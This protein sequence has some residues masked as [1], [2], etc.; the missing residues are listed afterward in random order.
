MDKSSRVFFLRPRGGTK[1]GHLSA[2][3]GLLC[4]ASGS[5]DPKKD[6]VGNELFTSGS[7]LW[8]PSNPCISRL[9][10]FGE[11]REQEFLLNFRKRVN[12]VIWA[13][14]LL[15]I[16]SKL[17][18]TG[19]FVPFVPRTDYFAFYELTRDAKECIEVH[20]IKAYNTSMGIK[21]K[22]LDPFF[23]GVR[24]RISQRVGRREHLQARS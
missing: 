16:L 19:S 23:Y 18:N 6:P 14:I 3:L 7:H 11:Q 24:H 10:G 5:C 9:S 22:G 13:Y 21:P 20:T 15:Y 17:E 1:S 12:R 4:L 8:A 2:C